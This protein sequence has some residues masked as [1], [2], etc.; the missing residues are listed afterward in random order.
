MIK[1]KAEHSIVGDVGARGCLMRIERVKDKKT[2][3]L[4]GKAGQRVYQKAFAKGLAW[5]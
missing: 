5:N 1:M 4:F 3:E 2:K